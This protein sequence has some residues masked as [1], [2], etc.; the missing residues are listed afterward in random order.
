M[1][2]Y[3]RLTYPGGVAV[4][5]VLKSPGAGVRKAVLLLAGTFVSG[6][7]HLISQMTGFE[8]W[9]LGESIGL[10]E[11]MNGV[12]YVSL[13]TIGVAFIAGRGGILFIIGGY[14]C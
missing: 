13:L 9:A 6:L 7:G 11:Y 8:N 12:W 1:I 3:E 14:V 5:T 10:P 2:D 4:A